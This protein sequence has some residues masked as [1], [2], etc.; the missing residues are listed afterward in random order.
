V[1]VWDNWPVHRHPDVWA[2][3]SELG[4]HHSSGLP[5]LRAVGR[6]LI[7]KLWRWLATGGD[8]LAP[9]PPINWRR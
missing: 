3:A 6:I 9:A 7:E 5:T 2:C 1:L 8:P 4:I